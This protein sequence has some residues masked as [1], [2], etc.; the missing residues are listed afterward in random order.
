MRRLCSEQKSL[1]EII[2]AI[3]DQVGELVGTLKSTNSCSLVESMLH[4]C[5]PKYYAAS[6][7]TTMR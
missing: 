2:S 3:V 6:Q 1:I 5:P 4:A 7:L